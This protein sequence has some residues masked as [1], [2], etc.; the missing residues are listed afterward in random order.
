MINLNYY[1]TI[2]YVKVMAENVGLGVV[3]HEEPV[4]P[5]ND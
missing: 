3:F 5:H 1:G 4:Q 2:K